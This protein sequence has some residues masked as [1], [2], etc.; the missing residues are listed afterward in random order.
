MK[1]KRFL[2][3]CV[4]PLLCVVILCCA[5]VT[6]VSAADSWHNNHYTYKQLAGDSYLQ[7]TQMV[8]GGTSIT[9]KSPLYVVDTG[10]AW[11]IS[12]IDDTIFLDFDLSGLG[13]SLSS[14]DQFNFSFNDAVFH[15]YEAT[16]TEQIAGRITVTPQYYF[17]REGGVGARVAGASKTYELE[18]RGTVY[19]QAF[20]FVN[21]TV[22]VPADCSLSR[23]GIEIDVDYVSFSVSV[24]GR[25]RALFNNG[26]YV[27]YGNPNSPNAPSYSRPDEG[28]LGALED[29]EQELESNTAEGRQ[30]VQEI[31]S[32]E[33]LTSTL[34]SYAKGLQFT[35][36][37]MLSAITKIPFLNALVWVSMSLGF[38]A[39]LFALSASIIAASDRRAGATARAGKHSRR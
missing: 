36:R 34:L 24:N 16:L 10:A 11:E 37:I 7:V 29:K 21:D 13:V 32:P 17:S 27:E 33:S 20:V 23:I 15:F 35:S 31:I 2:K 28:D 9:E 22:S 12:N 26:L 18:N 25:F 19:G 6:P 39:T 14:G 4:A 3:C 1:F 5:F 38:V 30:E 8:A